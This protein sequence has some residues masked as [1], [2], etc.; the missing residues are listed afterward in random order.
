MVTIAAILKIFKSHLLL[1]GVLIEL[2]H[3]GRR[4]GVMEIQN[5]KNRSF[6]M[7]KMAAI[8]KFF[9]PNVLPKSKTDGAET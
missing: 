1:N 9:K 2:K 7:A 6:P 3:D 5:F 4:L 8:L